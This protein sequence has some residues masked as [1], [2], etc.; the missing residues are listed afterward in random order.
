RAQRCRRHSY[1]ARSRPASRLHQHAF[2]AAVIGALDVRRKAVRAEHM[3][4]HFNDDVVGIDLGIVVIALESLQAR[5]TRGQHL[6]FAVE[7]IG[8]QLGGAG[9]D[10]TLL[11]EPYL[12]CHVRPRDRERS[13]FT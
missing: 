4:G 9:T 6:Y 11:A 1:I 8:T 13:G 12:R 5:W 10:F 7:T 2:D 3:A